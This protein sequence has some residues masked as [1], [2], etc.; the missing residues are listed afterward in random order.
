MSIDSAVR[1]RQRNVT[2]EIVQ[3][4][5]LLCP[6]NRLEMRRWARLLFLQSSVL[7]LSHTGAHWT[8]DVSG[9]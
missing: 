9:G 2:F 6:Q 3:V 1:G 7:P 8:K 4:I 5:E